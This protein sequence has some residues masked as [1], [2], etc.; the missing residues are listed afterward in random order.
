MVFVLLKGPVLTI[1]IVCHHIS[2]SKEHRYISTRDP[3]PSSVGMH[4]S[5]LGRFIF[6][7]E[8]Q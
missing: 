4:D 3:A 8:G 6:L 5:G 1:L 2:Q 7:A